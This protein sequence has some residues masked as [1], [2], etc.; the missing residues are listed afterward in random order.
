MSKMESDSYR[1][2][3]SRWN[4]LCQR[5]NIPDAQSSFENIVK[6]YSEPHRFYHNLNHL[7][8]CFQE[9]D[10][11]TTLLDNPESVELALWYHDLIHS[12]GQSGNEENSAQIAKV[13]CQ[14]Q[15]FSDY[16]AKQVEN[17]ILATKHTTISRHHDSQYLSD[18]DMAILGQS[19]DP[20]D[21]YESQICQEYSSIYLP[22]EYRKRR[23]VF[24]ETILKHPIYVTKFFHD[25]YEQTARQNIKSLIKKLQ[26]SD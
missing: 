24:L 4:G 15:N 14:S 18:I 20:F 21:I 25:R 7:Y 2:L 9:F 22:V 5:L 11:I 6:H 23:T 19:T 1:S 8:N 3:H 13:F 16:F 10:L 17:H 26:K 12:L